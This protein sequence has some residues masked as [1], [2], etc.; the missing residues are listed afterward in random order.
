MEELINFLLNYNIVLKTLDYQQPTCLPILTVC[1][2]LWTNVLYLYYNFIT[3]LPNLRKDILLL[4]EQVQYRFT[5]S[6]PSVTSLS[7]DDRFNHLRLTTL[8]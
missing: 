3:C 6:V 4:L 8:L 2:Y 7:Y 1:L 5:K